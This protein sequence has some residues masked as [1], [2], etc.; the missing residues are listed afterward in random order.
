M[1]RVGPLRSHASPLMLPASSGPIIAC[2]LPITG[3]M[4]GCAGTQSGA[5]GAIA[6]HQR[7]VAVPDAGSM[8]AD[9]APRGVLMLADN[10]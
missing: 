5:G 6:V 8:A 2:S 7:L 3:F 9:A 10:V 4:Q 1:F